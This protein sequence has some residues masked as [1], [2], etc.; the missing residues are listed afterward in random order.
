MSGRCPKGD[1]LVHFV[2]RIPPAR[3]R[4]DRSAADLGSRQD[5]SISSVPVAVVGLKHRGDKR[6]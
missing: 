2:A 6:L 5:A 3:A 4:S 1:R